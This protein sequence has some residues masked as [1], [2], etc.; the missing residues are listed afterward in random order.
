VGDAVRE[1]NVRP[2]ERRG[3]VRA[4]FDAR[5]FRVN[6]YLAPGDRPEVLM[7]GGVSFGYGAALSDEETLP[8]VLTRIGRVGVYN[9]GLFH[10]DDL[11]VRRLDQ[12]LAGL[13]ERPRAV[14]F[15]LVEH[16]RPT[17]PGGRERGGALAAA[18]P[19]LAPAVAR[20]Q[21]VRRELREADR[22][23][24]RWWAFSPLDVMTGRVFRRLSDD[25]VL[26]NEYA[27]GTRTL[28][29]PDG[30]PMVLRRYELA[31]TEEGR[32]PSDAPPVADYL[33]FWRDTLAARGL[34]THALLVPSRYTV[35][36]PL[37]EDR[38]AQRSAVRRVGAYLDRLAE[39]LHARGVP[40]VNAHPLFRA[41]AEDE[42]RTGELSF[43]REDN[44][45]TPR[46]VERVARVVADSLAAWDAPPASDGRA[47]GAK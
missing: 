15:L 16:E 37:L 2:T 7:L 40:T 9:G 46:G 45:W 25:R 26:P 21:G 43:Y 30:R 14:L 41:V 4:T 17:L 13:P 19:A 8:A 3:P 28:T 20:A 35:Y 31:P 38:A 24:R 12:I 22:L 33:A 1:A 18:Y 6:P 11:T 23:V 32:S 27:R 29:L 34:A 42:L 5:G 36:G 10:E 47:S 39:E 44:H